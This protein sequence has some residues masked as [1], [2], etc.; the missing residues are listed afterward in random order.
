MEFQIEPLI[1]AFDVDGTLI[2]YNNQPREDI[3]ALYRAFQALGYEMWV[4][5]GGGETYAESWCR[6][7]G[8]TAD[9]VFAKDNKLKPHLAIDDAKD[10]DLGLV[11]TLVVPPPIPGIWDR[12][13]A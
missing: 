9:R 1:V 12:K 13:E 7:L 2:D 4:W 5:S 6:R 11:T 3:I 8:I 10:A